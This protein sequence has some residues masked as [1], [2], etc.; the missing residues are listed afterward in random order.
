MEPS[1]DLL[2]T[3]LNKRFGLRGAAEVITELR[4]LSSRLW[5][6]P[7]SAENES[8]LRIASRSEADAMVALLRGHARR[9][10]PASFDE[11]ASQRHGD[12]DQRP[13]AEAAAV[14]VS[15]V[16][17]LGIAG[18]DRKEYKRLLTAL[19]H[20]AFSDDDPSILAR[21]AIL[22]GI[23]DDWPPPIPGI[24][25]LPWLPIEG[26]CIGEVLQ[27]ASRLG[28]MVQGS[29]RADSTIP[30]A[31][32]NGITGLSPNRGSSGDT[33]TIVGIFPASQPPGLTVMFPKAGG[34]TL[35]ATVLS[36]RSA[37][38][39]PNATEIE[40]IAPTPVGDGPVGF[41]T[42]PSAS[43]MSSLDPTAAI[44]F[45]D[46][47]GNCGGVVAG[48]VAG[49]MSHFPP[50]GVTLAAPPIPTLPG[51]VNVFHGGPVLVS[52][53]VDHA[54]EPDPAVIVNGLNLQQGDTVI[55]ENTPA[56]TTFVSATRLTFRVP[57]MV[58]GH[59]YLTIRRGGHRSNGA[60]FDV[61]AS[62]DM[63]PIPG[64]VMP[65]TWANLKGT[66]F[67]PEITAS[68]DGGAVVRTVNDTHNLDVLVR[69][70]ARTPLQSERRGERVAI[71]LFD[72]GRSL[73][74]IGILVGTFRIA[75]FGDS[76][77][78][79]QGLL[80]GDKFTNLAAAAVSK[81]RNG[82]IAVYSLDRSAHSGATTLPA[83]DPP[84]AGQPRL[85]GDFTGECPS[86]SPSVAAQ[87]RQWTT[88]ASL[89]SQR[90]EIDLVILDGG[91]NDVRI[92]Q[93]LNPFLFDGPL[94]S[95]TIAICG[96]A[97]VTLL[98]SVLATFPRAAIIVTGYY[99]I[100]S[101]QSDLSML[102]PALSGAGL[103][104]GLVTPL[105][106][107]A[108]PI[109]LDPIGALIFLAWIQERLRSRCAL[110]ATLANTMLQTS[111]TIA[112]A[113]APGRR[114][115]LAVPAFGPR[116]AIFAPD[117]FLWGVGITGGGLVPLDPVAAS[118]IAT[119][120]TGLVSTIASIGHPN[121][122]GAAAYGTAIEA[123]LPRVGL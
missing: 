66:G 27:A 61:R 94:I 67:G 38:G 10:R 49:R 16:L 43:E 9:V 95:D 115:A 52:T 12:V 109:G 71:E 59:V 60:A 24:D 48:S 31:D 6:A 119:C 76:I 98:G 92:G 45:A 72:R 21:R 78:W 68:L 102:L 100:V 22:G 69:R 82:A 83:S 105:I 19:V 37:L 79:G 25:D 96:P 15:G 34:G 91:I 32:A 101:E 62:L 13:R 108:V 118:R 65:G 28:G 41:F 26:D 46:A 88:R 123:A 39:S 80:E 55:L 42:N 1:V 8:F 122:N 3:E 5:T 20:V 86:L 17:A 23:G 106:P 18:P 11:L 111:V 40:V 64:R 2:A 57:P 53:S 84:D 97:M 36:W 87:V 50:G 4:E 114:I 110:F 33:V 103:L 73:G 74:T 75:S 7:P 56:P 63:T 107:G 35:S 113:A 112:M 93:I 121:V 77:V 81:R 14:L 89:N 70:P 90:S 116:N 120:G 29:R 117:P 99:Q 30:T 54:A 85:P 104:A 44:E 58:A 51:G 47:I